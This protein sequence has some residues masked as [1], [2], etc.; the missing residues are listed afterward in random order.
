M[1]YTTV[2]NNVEANGCVELSIG[3]AGPVGWRASFRRFRVGG[4]PC[5]L[6][7]STGKIKLGNGERYFL[8][9]LW[10][11]YGILTDGCNSYVLLKRSTEI[12]LRMNGDVTLETER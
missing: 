7:R 2:Y 10:K 1:P 11:S 6:A 5:L 9:K 12:R 3:H 8:R 4:D